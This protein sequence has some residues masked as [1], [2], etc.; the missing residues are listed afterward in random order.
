[1]IRVV[2]ALAI[3]P[4]YVAIAVNAATDTTFPGP[5]RVIQL[6]PWQSLLVGLV[7][8]AAYVVWEACRP[9]AARPLTEAEESRLRARLLATTRRIWV[10]G[11]LARSLGEVL[12]LELSLVSRQALVTHPAQVLLQGYGDDGD[13]IMT[14]G[15]SPVTVFKR[16]GQ[17]LLILGG[18]G[19]GK[20]T[21]LLE[22]ARD[23]IETSAPT[24]SVPVV[25]YLSSWPD[26]VELGKWAS[27]ELR[28]FYDLTEREAD[29]VIEHGMAALL[30]DGLDEVP[31][32]RLR[33]CVNALNRFRERHSG[34]PI[35]VTCR[36][37]HYHAEVKPLLKLSGAVLIQPLT[38][39][40]ADAWLA[41]IGPQLDG[42][43][44]S[45]AVDDA[46]RNL[47]R[48]PLTLSIAALAYQDTDIKTP[49]D[50]DSLFAAYTRRML[51]RPRAVLADGG[52]SDSDARR[53]LASLA[54]GLAATDSAGIRAGAARVLSVAWYGDNTIDWTWVRWRLA[55]FGVIPIAVI[56]AVT[57]LLL[58]PWQAAPVAAGAAALAAWVRADRPKW[59]IGDRTIEDWRLRTTD[60]SGRRESAS[61]V[62]TAGIAVVNFS[63]GWWMVRNL[64]STDSGWFGLLFI[65]AWI[66]LLMTV[67]ITVSVMLWAEG[68]VRLADDITTSV[69]T[70][71]TRPLGR[72]ATS[73]S[74]VLIAGA[75]VG[76]TTALVAGIGTTL[77][78]SA[79]WGIDPDPE[80]TLLGTFAIGPLAGFAAGVV[81]AAQYAVNDVHTPLEAYRQQVRIGSW[82]RD[83]GA[84]LA[85]ADGR[86]I[87]RKAGSEYDFVHRLY[88]DWWAR[89]S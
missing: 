71:L 4:I 80:I 81:Y 67:G 59:F 60:E 50:L 3:L 24:E 26:K 39:Q 49:V 42:L 54:Q 6:Y 78:K 41:S 40:E 76:A 28:R 73:V 62:L 34:T 65:G 46:L 23:L 20:T 30:L 74:A 86:I 29:H 13:G 83:L 89:H 18:P 68:T 63:F 55:A 51:S 82:P 66:L 36:I 5:L 47:L 12:R 15:A 22:L 7:A 57:T 58:G 14:S 87:L 43:R 16:F 69:L 9:G 88:R 1:M 75:V 64:A 77:A 38:E 37:D 84:F 70:W 48:T 45:I 8:T 25:L 19:A 17:K 56:A 2:L 32:A 44:A 61:T 31:T 52:Y 33:A 35:A 53:W 21:M 85:W 10:D 11:V 72:L 27:D 79:Y